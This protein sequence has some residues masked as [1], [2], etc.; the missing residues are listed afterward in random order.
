[1]KRRVLLK[2]GTAYLLSLG[3]MQMSAVPTMAQETVTESSSEMENT[4]QSLMETVSSAI[5]I[6]TGNESVETPETTA[7]VTESEPTQPQESESIPVTVETS[8]P[9]QESEMPT[10]EE[11]TASQQPSQEPV[12]SSEASETQPSETAWETQTESEEETSEESTEELSSEEES[13]EES[14]GEGI[15]Q[16][17]Y[18]KAYLSSDAQIYTGW[19]DGASA[20]TSL[21][22]GYPV[23]VT[24][25]VLFNDE[26]VWAR[27]M[28]DVNDYSSEGYIRMDSL[29]ID[30]SGDIMLLDADEVQSFP[31]D[32]QA[33]LSALQQA[34]P[35]WIF[36]PIYVG[37]TFSYAVSQQMSTP[38][39]AL[40]SMYC[41][42]GYRSLLD[43]DYDLRTN[44][45]KQWEPNWAGASEETVRYY[46]DP[47]NF[48]N[49]NDIF[50]FESLTYEEYQSQS[51]VEAALANCFMS[52]AVVPGTNYT[53]SWLFCWIGEKYNINPVALASRV[54]QEQGSGASDM[55]SGKY[56]G[57]EGLYNYFNLQATGSTRDEI[58]QNGLK[59]AHVGSTMMLPDGSVSSGAWNTPEKALIGGA[60]KFAN[61]YI[62]RNQNT[63][64]AQKFDYDGKYNGKYWHQYMTN[65][66]APSSEG[67]QVRRSYSATGQLENSFVFLIPVYEERPASS[68]KPAEH[69]NQNAYL[70]SLTVN[71]KEVIQT[72]DK[73][74]K[75]FYYNVG[76]NTVYANVKAKASATTSSVAFSNIET[77]SHKVETTKIK[78]T[79]EDGSTAEYR[80][81][82][83][84]GVE[85]KDGFFDGFD[86]DAYRKRY[87]QLN[88]QYGDDIDA[89]YEHYLLTGK[90][91][92]WDGST[93]GPFPDDTKKDDTKKD[94][95]NNN[96]G[97]NSSARPAA[98]Y[99]GVNY[100]PV[101][102]AQ[103]YLS[104]YPDLKAAFG[105]DTTAALKHFVTYGIKEGRQ[106]CAEF[107]VDI[108]KNNYADL[109][110]AFGNDNSAYVKHYLEY[111]Q[112][113]GRNAQKLIEKA[114]DNKSDNNKSDDNNNNNQHVASDQ[115]KKYSGVYDYTYYRNA[116]ADLR[117]AFGNDADKYF[118]HFL[119]CGMAEGRQASENF[120]VKTYK[121]NYADLHKAFGNNNILYYKHYLEYGKAEGRKAVASSNSGNNGNTNNGNTGSN[122]GNNTGN[123]TMPSAST[124]YNGVDYALVYDYE[125]YKKKYAD[126]RNTFGDDPKKYLQHFVENGMREG[127]QASA[128]FNVSAYKNRYAD[129]RAAFG[130]NTASYYMHYI[131]N[132]KAEGRTAN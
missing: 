64:Y 12:E 58:L 40:V 121:N 127:R 54:R 131:K 74:K 69:K 97:N 38:A 94:D 27:I 75:D 102:D 19:E 56:P 128:S 7:Q 117:A 99:N 113:E 68:P 15:E 16:V 130:N 98:V 51:A 49:E 72:F 104:K 70:N 107:D 95:N 65:I 60:L 82:I 31:A 20:F 53:Y 100:A 120:D 36:K 5:E 115:E 17:Y 81:I 11:T 111:G 123:N 87:P 45:W 39:R 41:N 84:R 122:T 106:A 85:I 73:N 63:L 66:M 96:S 6:T 10:Q 71:D 78:V 44:T 59:E 48:L 33:A 112:K 90:A 116:Y 61:Q 25:I 103:Y 18:A 1:M 23:Y 101:F 86:V 129:L 114:D 32:Y 91:A 119:Q 124:V 118:K 43:R 88:K 52:N 34:H 50:M 125:Y 42:E 13:T 29:Q 77:M 30:G 8:V 55:I 83:G 46:M 37:D 24:S 21:P 80:L 2:K 110:K 22:S 92:G 132:G 108:Y 76:S 3:V 4:V 89:Y 47:R 26:P 109:K 93:N 105:S 67:G 126:L 57:Y 62:L 28:F 79:A 9:S 14:L 35:N